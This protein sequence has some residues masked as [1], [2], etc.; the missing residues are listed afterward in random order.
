MRELEVNVQELQLEIQTIE[1]YWNDEIR[2]R[3]KAEDQVQD[4]KGEVRNKKRKMDKMD[5]A[6]NTLV[7][8]IQDRVSNYPKEEDHTRPTISRDRVITIIAEE[9][10]EALERG[11]RG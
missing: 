11:L 7:G 8:R 4:L 3:R 5:C 1:A 10:E 6:Y 2:D 9:N